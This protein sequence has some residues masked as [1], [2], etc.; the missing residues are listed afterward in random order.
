MN[1]IEFKQNIYQSAFKAAQ[2]GLAIADKNDQI[3]DVNRALCALFEKERSELTGIKV[4][5]L[6]NKHL[7]QAKIDL[8]S[9]TMLDNIPDIY[10]FTNNNSNKY[11]SVRKISIPFDKNKNGYLLTL[12]EITSSINILK[13]LEKSESDYKLLTNTIKDAIIVYDLINKIT[14]VNDRTPE[15][16]EIPKNKILGK[17]IS[18]FLPEKYFDFLN[19]KK[20]DLLNNCFDNQFKELEIIKENGETIDI[21]ATCSP[22]PGGTDNNSILIVIRDITYRKILEKQLQK[23]QRM[24]AVKKMAGGIAHDFNNLLT[25]IMGNNKLLLDKLKNN[26]AVGQNLMQI[27][28]ACQRAETLTSQLLSFSGQQSLHPQ[29][30]DIN[31]LV[32]SLITLIKQ[33]LRKNITLESQLDPTVSKTLVDPKKLEISIYNLISNAA[34]NMTAEG[35]KIITKT[36]AYCLKDDCQTKHLFTIKTGD[37]VL[38]EIMYPAIDVQEDDLINAFEPFQ[39]GNK[40]YES[41][42]LDLPSIYGFMKQSNGYIDIESIKE[43]NIKYLLYFPVYADKD[44]SET[45]ISAE[46]AKPLNRPNPAILVAEDEYDLNE[47][48]C[49]I[50]EHHGYDVMFALNGKE[51]LDIVK[52]N[53]DKIDLVLS[54]VIMP[55]MG[56]PEFVKAAKKINKSLNIIYMSGYTDKAISLIENDDRKFEFLQKPF[57]PD[58][59][60]SKIKS[61]IRDK[62]SKD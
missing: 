10:T 40:L 57:T 58:K 17:N 46:A 54:D 25:I 53:P 9:L 55:E 8:K 2:F 20:E 61:L 39:S 35:G 16:L 37:Y 23:T 24:N 11:V 56:G 6:I 3:I 60:L 31:E 7:E 44:E 34:E 41:T 14:Y 38:L 52:K 45:P 15:L 33:T 5:N 32:S 18:D 42:G 59:L 48:I 4:D 27:E 47:M 43:E 51:A 49:D 13:G 21:E 30:T 50:L 62:T 36:S 19:Q 12:L 28:K 22:I 1:N 29:K 26:A